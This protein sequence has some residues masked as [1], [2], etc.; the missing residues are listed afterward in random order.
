MSWIGVEMEFVCAVGVGIF[1]FSEFV[2]STA[3]EERSLEQLLPIV[4]DDDC[5]VLIDTNEIQ[6]EWNKNNSIHSIEY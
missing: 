2:M 4:I 5:T 6:V 1:F 3:V